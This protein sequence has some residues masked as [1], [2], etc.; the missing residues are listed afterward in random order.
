M[1]SS[2]DQ[3]LY[4]DEFYV[5]LQNDDREIITLVM[6]KRHMALE[7]TYQEWEELRSGRV[8]RRVGV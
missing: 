3:A 8:D 4:E 1:G 5:V 7:F 6:S 2:G